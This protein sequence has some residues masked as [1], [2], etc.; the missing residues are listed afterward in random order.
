MKAITHTLLFLIFSGV[1]FGQSACNSKLFM[2]K[3]NFSNIDKAEVSDFNVNNYKQINCELFLEI[4][5][6][7]EKVVAKFI[8]HKE[9]ILYDSEGKLY[10]LYFSKTNQYFQIEGNSFQLSKSQSLTLSKLFD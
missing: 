9:V 1:L 4:V 6:H 3:Y 2:N 10:K 8:P 7:S 5:N